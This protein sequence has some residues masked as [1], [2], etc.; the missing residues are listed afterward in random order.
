M[1][2]QGPRVRFP[3]P[4]PFLC[5]GG[6]SGKGA[7]FTRQWLWVRVPPWVPFM[8]PNAT[9]ERP[10]FHPDVRGSIPRGSAIMCPARR[11]QGVLSPVAGGF[12]SPTGYHALA[13]WN[14]PGL[15]S[16][17]ILGGM[18]TQTCTSC[19]KVLP[20]TQFTWKDR[21]KTKRHNYCRSCKAE[22]N[23]RWYRK[24]KKKHLQ[25]V[26]RNRSKYWQS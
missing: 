17:A 20:L 8:L 15:L 5:P 23:R 22:Y 11:C 10:G 16:W 21:K 12:D 24:N 9:G 13:D 2:C 3:A 7:V 14:G 19:K 4:P 6:L 25:D 18:T 1:A 26:E